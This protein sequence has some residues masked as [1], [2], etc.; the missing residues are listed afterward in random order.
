M[1]TPP[2]IK[3]GDFE[4]GCLNHSTYSLEDL[5]HSVIKNVRRLSSG[6]MTARQKDALERFGKQDLCMTATLFQRSHY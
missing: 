1:Y 4:A 5:S 3:D 2:P 6:E